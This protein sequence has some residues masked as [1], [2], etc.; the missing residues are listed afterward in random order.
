[1][2]S[3]WT[4]TS[5]NINSKKNERLSPSAL[6]AFQRLSTADPE[7]S[8]EKLKHNLEKAL[9]HSKENPPQLPRGIDSE[10]QDFASLILARHWEEH[11]RYEELKNDPEQRGPNQLVFKAKT[12][13]LPTFST[14]NKSQVVSFRI[15]TPSLVTADLISQHGL[16]EPGFDVNSLPFPQMTCYASFENVC[17]VADVESLTLE[18]Q[19]IYEMKVTNC[20]PIQ[21]ENFRKLSPDIMTLCDL[22]MDESCDSSDS[23]ASRHH[24]K[25][26]PHPVNPRF[27]THI[28][29]SE[30]F[31]RLQLPR[32][33]LDQIY[34]HNTQ[35]KKNDELKKDESE[36][37]GKTG[38]TIEGKQVF[39]NT[40]AWRSF[41]KLRAK[42]IKWDNEVDNNPR[43]WKM[44]PLN[45][46]LHDLTT[47]SQEALIL[48]RQQRSP[49]TNHQITQRIQ[50]M[51]KNGGKVLFER[52]NH[53]P[54]KQFF[55]VDYV[56]VPYNEAVP[57]AA[58]SKEKREENERLLQEALERE[59]EKYTFWPT[60]NRTWG[61]PPLLASFLSSKIFKK[62]LGQVFE[63]N[64]KKAK[65]ISKQ[66]DDFDI[67]S[68][69]L[70]DFDYPHIFWRNPKPMEIWEDTRPVH[71]KCFRTKNTLFKPDYYR[72]DNIYTWDQDDRKYPGKGSRLHHN[73]ST[74][75]RKHVDKHEDAG[76]IGN[77]W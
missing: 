56:K 67:S 2:E 61:I 43:A 26:E 33:S 51:K 70:K 12:M 21:P 18:E 55:E 5:P 31:Q 72:G 35:L 65:R 15:F 23:M 37:N 75:Y 20:L 10:T 60:T 8:A 63:Q 34:V 28:L 27:A 46:I 45:V 1:M 17:E 19:E 41:L 77:S 36:T 13:D 64:L 76:F 69:R 39:D 59:G 42:E 57:N 52:N 11:A 44:A 38:S 40:E 74:D 54:K 53:F 49:L 14:S 3:D 29:I 22:G 48:F 16:A 68:A 9:N 24:Q 50:S 62:A 25:A 66:I 4:S 71:H 30:E 47:L 7:S 32:S 6:R 73:S 58:K